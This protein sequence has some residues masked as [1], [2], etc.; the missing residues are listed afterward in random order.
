MSGSSNGW[1][2]EECADEWG[3]AGEIIKYLKANGCIVIHKCT[4]I[5]HAKV[6]FSY[7]YITSKAGSLADITYDC[8]LQTAV[9]LGADV[10]SIDGF[11]CPSSS[12]PLTSQLPC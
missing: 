10:L 11:E 12:P 9:R 8:Y 1:F 3:A 2:G 4:T 6:S 5:R 7:Q